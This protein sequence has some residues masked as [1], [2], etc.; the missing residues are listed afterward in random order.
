MHAGHGLVWWRGHKFGPVKAFRTRGITHCFAVEDILQV[1]LVQGDKKGLSFFVKLKKPASV[2][3]WHGGRHVKES[4]TFE[5]FSLVF[6]TQTRAKPSGIVV[7]PSV[8]T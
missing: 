6:S 2:V 1:G 5:P 8:A 7:P 3:T 4:E